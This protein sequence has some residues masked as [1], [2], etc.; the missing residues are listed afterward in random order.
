MAGESPSPFV[1]T[2]TLMP[3]WAQTECD[4]FTGTT[5]KSITLPPFSATR[6]A[7]IRPASPPPTMMTRGSAMESVGE[8]VSR[9]DEMPDGE[10]A[11]REQAEAQRVED[12]AARVLRARTD[13]ETPADA[14]GPEAV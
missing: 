4:R 7:A 8:G 14:E 12:H 11:D 6:I 2:A 10:P 9:R 1:C 3:P 13:G 5:E